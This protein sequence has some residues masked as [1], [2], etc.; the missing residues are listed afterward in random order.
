METFA[1]SLILSVVNFAAHCHLPVAL[2]TASA[3]LYCNFLFV[4]SVLF[5][6]GR[7][8]RAIDVPLVKSWY[9]EHCPPGQPVKVRVSYQ[10]LLKYFVLNALK[11]RAPKPQKKRLV[12]CIMFF[13]FCCSKRLDGTCQYSYSYSYNDEAE[14]V[15]YRIYFLC[16]LTFK[17]NVITYAS[18]LG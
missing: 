16:G 8:R 18:G 3:I 4:K 17:V 7:T 2:Q 12:Q 14:V 11:H 5:Y 6:L 1:R 10:K 15:L 13:K 9:R